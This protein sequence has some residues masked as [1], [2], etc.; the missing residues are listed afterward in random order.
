MARPERV[1]ST[2]AENM[3]SKAICASLLL[4][5]CILAQPPC[6]AQDSGEHRP[7]QVLFLGS[8]YTMYNG[9]VKM[10]QGLSRAAGVDRKAA[11]EQCIIGGAS[12]QSHWDDPR[13]LKK[14][15][16][17][18]WDVVVLQGHHYVYRGNEQRDLTYGR[19]LAEE[20]LKKKA[21]LIYYM[22]WP[23]RPDRGNPENLEKIRK[24]YRQLR[25]QT[26]GQIAAAGDAFALALAKRPDLEKDLYFRDG[27]HPGVLG[28]YLVACSVFSALYERTPVGLPGK[29]FPTEVSERR[30]EPCCDVDPA[31]ARFLQEVAWEAA[32]KIRQPRSESRPSTQEADARQ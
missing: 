32:Q 26:G 21:R 27:Y 25:G 7:L 10:V 23:S 5:G 29:L 14:L 4:A 12:F 28:S 20:V 8:S 13:S 24:V 6:L 15:R 3:Q 16:D 19:K 9:M 1:G 18:D 30:N 11:C 2:G 17:G 31:T 22:L